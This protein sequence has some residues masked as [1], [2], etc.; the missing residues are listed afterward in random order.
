MRTGRKKSRHLCQEA[1]ET[2]IYSRHTKQTSFADTRLHYDMNSRGKEKKPKARL[3]NTHTH[4]HTHT[5]I[6]VRARMCVCRDRERPNEDCQSYW[7][8]VYKPDGD[9]TR[10]AQMIIAPFPLKP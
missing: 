4:T 7:K 1:E 2:T 5:Y 9:G 8:S 3:M 6:Y 10:L